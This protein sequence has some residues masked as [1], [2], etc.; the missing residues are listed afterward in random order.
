[1][2]GYLLHRT[3]SLEKKYILLKKT[4]PTEFKDAQRLN[5]SLFH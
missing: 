1:M 5:M 2:V 4:P 3:V